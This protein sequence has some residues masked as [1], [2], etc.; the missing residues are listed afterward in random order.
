MLLNL[1]APSSLFRVFFP[2]L[3][4]HMASL[5]HLSHLV[6]LSDS[7]SMTLAASHLM[8]WLVR[9]AWSVIADLCCS[10]KEDLS[11]DCVFG[12][13]SNF[14]TS[15]WCSNWIQLKQHLFYQ[16]IHSTPSTAASSSTKGRCWVDKVASLKKLLLKQW[17][18]TK[19]V[20]N[21]F[22]FLGFDKINF[23]NLIIA[24]NP[25]ELGSKM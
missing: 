24:T 19:I 23:T 4:I 5:T 13:S 21:I 16:L 6:V 7:E 9:T 17:N 20:S 2:F 1:Y 12:L 22:N 11:E 8:L 18:I 25:D 3:Q 15:F 10:A 14:S